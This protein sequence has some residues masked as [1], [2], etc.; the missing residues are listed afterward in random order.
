MLTGEVR[1]KGYYSRVWRVVG[2][3]PLGA[4]HEGWLDWI[5]LEHWHGVGIGRGCGLWINNFTVQ[6]CV[7]KIVISQQQKQIP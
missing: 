1:M 3:Q 4:G 7:R 2:H 5:F 6:N